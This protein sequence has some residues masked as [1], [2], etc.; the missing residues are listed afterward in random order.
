[1]KLS[2][3]CQ[4]L[5]SFCNR[6]QPRA[7]PPLPHPPALTASCLQVGIQFGAGGDSA[8]AELAAAGTVDASWAIRRAQAC[9]DAGAAIVMVESE[10]EG[11]RTAGVCRG[12]SCSRGDCSR[13][14]FLQFRR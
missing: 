10:G 2:H 4:H 1:M 8:V 6:P 3:C 7:C 9:L 14:A 12:H 5:E 13:Q 11:G